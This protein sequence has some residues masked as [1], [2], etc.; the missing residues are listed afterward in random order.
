MMNSRRTT[1]D[2]RRR[3]Q[4]FPLPCSC[5]P[6]LD[7]TLGGS[8]RTRGLESTAAVD[9]GRGIKS[10]AR[11]L[12]EVSAPRVPLWSPRATSR[13]MM[14]LSCTSPCLTST[15]SYREQARVVEKSSGENQYRRVRI[16][17]G[18]SRTP[19]ETASGSTPLNKVIAQE[20]CGSARP[21]KRALDTHPRSGVPCPCRL[22]SIL[23]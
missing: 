13:P 4:A 18:T 7:S 22:R 5:S 12:R 8:P 16:R 23:N 21:D 2:F 9:Q 3:R 11:W 20:A 14:V 15:K 19:R 6:R 1:P 10:P 17:G